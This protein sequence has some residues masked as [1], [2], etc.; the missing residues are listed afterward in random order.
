[1]TSNQIEETEDLETLDI[2]SL[3][4][5]DSIQKA[6]DHHKTR[7]YEKTKYYNQINQAKRDMATS[8]RENLKEIKEEVDYELNQL[9]SLVDKLKIM[10][11]S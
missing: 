7:L 4:D 2:D 11:A 5:V 9:D 1:L 6:I 8:Y 3:N 10:N